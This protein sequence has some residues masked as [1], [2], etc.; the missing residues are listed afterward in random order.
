M[1]QQNAAML[2][3]VQP[4]QDRRRR[5]M[6]DYQSVCLPGSLATGWIFSGLV[7]SFGWNKT[8]LVTQVTPVKGRKDFYSRKQLG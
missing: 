7:A 8:I 4:A 2:T 5:A 3:L 6:E 1:S